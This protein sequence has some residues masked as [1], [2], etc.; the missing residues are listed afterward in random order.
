MVELV[1]TPDLGSGIA[2]CE[3]SSLSWGTI[4]KHIK[5]HP[6]DWDSKMALPL[7]CFSIER[8]IMTTENVAICPLPFKSISYNIT[9]IVGPCTSCDLTQYKSINDYWQSN[10]LKQLRTDMLNGIR[11]PACNTC[12]LREDAGAW[13]MR[14]HLVEVTTDFDYTNKNP[15]L[16]QALL[17]FSNVCNYMCLDCNSNTSSLIYKEEI[18]RGLRAGES[19][20][21]FAGNDPDILINQLK[22]HVHTLKTVNFSGGEPLVQWQHWEM[23]KY[24]VEQ[25]VSPAVTYYTNLSKLYYKKQYLIDYLN[26]FKN[27]EMVVG[28]DAMGDGCDYFRRGMDFY[29]TIEN[30]QTV[31]KEAPHVKL[32]IV[33][34][35]T[36]L[37]AINAVGMIE[38]IYRNLPGQA[39]SMNLVLHEH[40]DMRVA[41]QFKK[42]QIDK[43]LKRLLDIPSIQSEMVEG[44]INYLWSEDQSFKFNDSL[45]WLKGIDDWRKQDFR[46]VFPEHKDIL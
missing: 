9:G 12:Y 10:E 40:L 13:T 22:E 15:V 43:A 39:V 36:W 46:K 31:R 25:N 30:I 16:E 18:K 17:R 24:M 32:D 11:N 3:S 45:K 33:T 4:L 42:N 6:T 2:R 29:E 35:F 34:T 8:I 7:V 41:P 27:V 21:L 23:I 44:L 38:W 26:H 14:K 28:F 5:Q 19:P 1:D 37:N 20:I